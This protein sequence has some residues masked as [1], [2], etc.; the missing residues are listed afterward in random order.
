MR[1]EAADI[2]QDDRKMQEMDDVFLH[3][4]QLGSVVETIMQKLFPRHLEYRNKDRG[5]Q[6]QVIKNIFGGGY[7]MKGKKGFL[8][9]QVIKNKIILKYVYA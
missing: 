6:V 8:D 4:T 7:H 5:E 9:D 3:E 2:V 1:F